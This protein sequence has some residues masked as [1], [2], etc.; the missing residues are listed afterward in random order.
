MK[1]LSKSELGILRYIK[2]KE[3]IILTSGTISKKDYFSSLNE[4]DISNPEFR[5][6]LNYDKDPEILKEFNEE[7]LRHFLQI[8]YKKT[9]P[10]SLSIFT[11]N[12]ELLRRTIL[13]WFHRNT[14]FDP[15]TIKILSPNS[16]NKIQKSLI[17][18]I[19]TMKKSRTTLIQIVNAAPGTGKTTAANTLA[20]T[21]RE[22]GVLLISYTNESI[23]ENY[24]RFFEFPEGK[25]NSGL[26]KYGNNTKDPPLINLAT[27]DS[28]AARIIGDSSDSQFDRF[29]QLASINIDPNKFIH[30]KRKRIYNHIIVD[31][32]QDID[33]LRGN[34]ILT[35]C[36][37]IGIQSLTLFGDPRQ[38]IRGQNGQWYS[39]LWE[40]TFDYSKNGHKSE[41]FE[42]VIRIG[43]EETYR[44]QEES[45]LKLVNTLSEVRPTLHVELK[46]PVELNKSDTDYKPIEIIPLFK[47]FSPGFIEN[48]LSKS[49]STCIIGPSIEADNKTTNAGRSIAA[50]FK[51][52]GKNISF[53]NDGA[54]VPDAIPFLT[55]HSVKGREFDSVFLF[56]M[57][58]YPN[59]FS[60]IPSEEALS[61][62]FVAHSRAKR[63]IYYIDSSSKFTLPLNV[64]SEF[65]NSES[66]DGIIQDSH[67]DFDKI[68]SAKMRH[69]DVKA[70]VEDHSF[71]RFI[72]ENRYTINKD[73]NP[74][75]AEDWVSEAK[76]KEISS[77]LWGFILSFDYM[78]Q[79]TSYENVFNYYFCSILENKYIVLAL[80]VIVKE[81]LEGNII[82]N[83]KDGLRVF[84]KD[85]GSE[86]KILIK[87]IR[88]IKIPLYGDILYLYEKY[89][90]DMGNHSLDISTLEKYRKIFKDKDKLCSSEI[91]TNALKAKI[92]SEAKFGGSI[93]TS[94]SDKDFK[95]LHGKIDYI[96]SNMNVYELK[97]TSSS[98]KEFSSLLQV[99]L[100]YVLNDEPESFA[101]IIDLQKGIL[102]EITSNESIYRWRYLIRSYFIVRHHV[103]LVTARRNYLLNYGKDEE[104]KR[105]LDVNLHENVFSVDTEFANQK[106]IFE[107]ALVNMKDP[108]RTIV[109]LCRPASLEGMMF[110]LDWLPHTVT[111]MYKSSMDR[112]KTTFGLNVGK[113]SDKPILTYYVCNVDVEWCQRKDTQKIDL[114][115]EARKI[116]E[117]C[118]TFTGGNMSPKLGELYT[119]FAPYPL[120]FQS[121]LLAHTAVCDALMLYELVK[122]GILKIN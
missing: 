78:S 89:F 25:S 40:N 105:I 92:T 36:R 69:F 5:D 37:K 66:Y 107:I 121:H 53:R 109:D 119:T 98:A 82:N 94:V 72:E 15:D 20:Y 30:P 87:N 93:E 104:K 111:E 96:D 75:R 38:R 85:I 47:L 48:I 50:A 34:F 110:A 113:F 120:E 117:K 77:S 51:E 52:A 27:V 6:F 65:V 118:G 79:L 102:Y 97:S 80:D 1:S 13:W 45:I 90:D 91:L 103:D 23:K 101:Y 99:W 106:D 57:S 4:S 10:F 64:K 61:L 32:C 7:A 35:F 21:L 3:K 63:K 26:K 44:F 81:Q 67:S 8:K 42:P 29:I 41:N 9:F 95:V 116:S 22:E 68:N 56:G 108:Y 49:G 14:N 115:Y 2:T 39:E 76:P 84:S 11:N 112:V 12:K 28:L 18:N 16:L 43:F 62:I 100:Y 46:A 86:D 88:E 19:L 17:D 73:E 59:S 70:L 114:S 33:D 122:L 31:E 58:N 54:Y 24:K 55:I 83:Y 74:Y 71:L 60:M